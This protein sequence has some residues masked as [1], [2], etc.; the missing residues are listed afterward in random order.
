MT[1]YSK[2]KMRVYMQGRR[3]ADPEKYKAYRKQPQVIAKAR[4]R[5]LLKR[6]GLDLEICELIFDSQGRRCAICQ[7]DDPGKRGGRLT[8]ITKPARFGGFCAVTATWGSAIS[9][10]ARGSWRLRSPI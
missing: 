4:N 8:I 2:E 1:A 3:A 7:T 6:Y 5:S 10:T 9:M